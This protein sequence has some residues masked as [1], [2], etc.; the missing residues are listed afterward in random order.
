MLFDLE[1]LRRLSFN[2]GMASTRGPS[3]NRG[4]AG[5]RPKT[6]RFLYEVKLPIVSTSETLFVAQILY[7]E[8]L[9]CDPGNLLSGNFVNSSPNLAHLAYQLS[10]NLFSVWPDILCCTLINLKYYLS[11]GGHQGCGQRNAVN[12]FHAFQES[13]KEKPSQKNSTI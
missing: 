4:P 12:Q 7:S 3:T 8:K 13:V 6:H 1:N 9:T 5:S 11:P 10:A 2:S